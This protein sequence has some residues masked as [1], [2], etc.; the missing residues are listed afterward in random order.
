[1]G[2]CN[3][4]HPGFL[5]HSI[6]GLQHRLDFGVLITVCR[7]KIASHGVE[8]CHFDGWVIQ[9]GSTEQLD[10]SKSER[11]KNLLAILNF[12]LAICV[13]D[14]IEISSHSAKPRS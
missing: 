11:H 1:M 9:E 12:P 10:I 13:M 4:D 5:S 3:H 8:N 7:S 6:Q 14:G 2:D